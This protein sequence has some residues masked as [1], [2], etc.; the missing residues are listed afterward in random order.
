MS[1]SRHA[2]NAFG[3]DVALDEGGA[4]GDRRTACLVGEAEPPAGANSL[5]RG[6][7]ESEL[8]GERFE[9]EAEVGEVVD[10]RA[11]VELADGGHR[12]G[13]SSAAAPEITRWPMA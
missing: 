8:A 10:Q 12:T 5:R 6:V 11:E 3:D 7:V 4:A 2:E 13:G 1:S 9:R